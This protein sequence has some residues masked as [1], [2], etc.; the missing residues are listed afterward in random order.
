[1]NGTGVELLL[2]VVYV[3]HHCPSGGSRYVSDPVLDI[4]LPG[5]RH[6]LHS[7]RGR[8]MTSRKF[9]SEL[10]TEVLDE[11]IAERKRQTA[12]YGKQKHCNE[13]WLA[14]AQEELGETASE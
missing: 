2:Y 13:V 10:L 1:C 11:I 14:I 4:H 5:L 12:K 6:C 8:E 3:H 7:T 9:E